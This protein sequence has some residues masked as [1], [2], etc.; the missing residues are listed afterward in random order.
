MV[1]SMFPLLQTISRANS[2]LWT[3]YWYPWNGDDS[4]LDYWGPPPTQAEA[5]IASQLGIEAQPTLEIIP[6]TVTMR[7]YRDNILKGLVT[8]KVVI[9]LNFG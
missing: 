1:S 6:E 3:N 2:V 8:V 5:T 9:Y 4:A 7:L